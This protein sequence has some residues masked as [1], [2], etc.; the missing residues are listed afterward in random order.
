MG[1]RPP[2]PDMVKMKCAH[3]HPGDSKIVSRPLAQWQ[4]ACLLS[5]VSWVRSPHGLPSGRKPPRNE[6]VR[7]L[8]R[9]PQVGEVGFR[10]RTDPESD[11][12]LRLAE[13]EVVDDECRLRSVVN[14]EPRLRTRHHDLQPRPCARLEVDVGLVHPRLFLA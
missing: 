8:P 10:A 11:R 9:N 5:R 3:A 13:L 7:A 4:S 6:Y 1:S 12:A 2:A 14:E